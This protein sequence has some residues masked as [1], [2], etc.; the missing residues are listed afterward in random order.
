MVAG[1]GLSKMTSRVCVTAW[2]D[3]WKGCDLSVCGA[4]CGLFYML[5]G[6][7]G[8]KNEKKFPELLKA[9]K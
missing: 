4:W 1:D 7:Q 9:L 8:Y 5:A 2:W 6:S 3:G